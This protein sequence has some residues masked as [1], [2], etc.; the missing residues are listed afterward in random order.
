[1]ETTREVK[2]FLLDVADMIID[3]D[4]AYVDLTVRSP[5]SGAFLTL[6]VSITDMGA[7]E[8]H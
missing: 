6:R 2:T 3:Q 4:A 8:T 5:D 1:M 7:G